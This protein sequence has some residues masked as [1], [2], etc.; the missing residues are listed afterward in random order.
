VA[1]DISDLPVPPSGPDISDL[2]APPPQ[3]GS[4]E[5]IKNAGAGAVLGALGGNVVGSGETVLTGITG[6]A[7]SLADAVTGS[8]PG[9]HDWAYRPRTPWGQEQSS[10]LGQVAGAANQA[11]AKG[12]GAVV[13]A[14][15]GNAQA[16]QDTLAERLPEAEGAISTVVPLVKGAGG[17]IEA[18][19]AKP[20]TPAAITA[21]AQ[22]AADKVATSGNAGAAGTAVDVTKLTPETQAELAKVGSSGPVNSTALTRTSEA[23]SLPVPVRLT[24][25]QA[26]GDAGMIS[27][28]FNLKGEDNNA[29]GQRYDDQDQALR[30]NLTTLHREASP[31]TVA[32]DPIQN[33]QALVDSLKRYDQ[34]KVA[35]INAAYDD[36]NAANVAAGKGGLTLDP[37]P[38]VAHA[39]QVLEDRADLLPSEGQSILAKLKT[40]QDDGTSIPL[41]QAETWR[42]TVA[43]ATRKYDQAGDTNAVR[44][45]SDFRDSLEQLTPNNAATTDVAA[46]YTAARNL[47]KARFDELDADPAYQAAVG[48]ETPI[49]EQSDLADKF[50]DKYVLNGSKAALQRLRPK[51]DAEGSQAMTSSAMDF[52]QRKAGINPDTGAG[53][54]SNAGYNSGLAK[55]MPK[56]QELLGRQ[57]LVD[58]VRKVGNVAGY[59]QQLSRGVYA[60]TSHTFVA[61][62]KGVIGKIAGEVPVVG[63]M[64]KHASDFLASRSRAAAAREAIKPGAGLAD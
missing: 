19:T 34:P 52:L 7:G 35:A 63:G 39:A 56:A 41:K 23:E 55:I 48:D 13:G 11:A 57:D 14:L 24:A 40:A 60:N 53:K 32:N 4:A 3:P 62:A 27:D 22:A 51:L 61:A 28:E 29:I 50:A 31:D 16:A 5:A 46:K 33:G 20:P 58:N 49:G 10:G 1:Q 30:D 25:G 44:A 54:F 42:T 6:G 37:A 43:R 8:A 17:L 47:A 18:A 12:G 36:A 15:G 21:A 59:T 9:T 45:L 64:Y 26:R 38:A 2:P